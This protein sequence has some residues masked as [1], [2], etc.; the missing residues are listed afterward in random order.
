[1]ILNPLYYIKKYLEHKAIVLMYHR[2]A[3]ARA[4][5]WDIAV[6]PENLEEQLKFLKKT[7]SVIPLKE[8]VTEVQNKWI[9][10]N[11]IAITF[12]DGYAD[13]F[14]RAKPLLEKYQLPAT[15]FIPSIN[16]GKQKEF[17]WDELEHLILFTKHLPEHLSINI[18]GNKIE[19]DLVDEQQLND[20]II[21]K[22]IAW[23]AYKQ[24]PPTLRASLFYEIWEALKP[25]NNEQQQ[26]HL[27]ILRNWMGRNISIRTDYQC[28]SIEQIKELG[29]N[30]L[31]TIEAHS[32]THAALAFHDKIFQK[33]ELE[34]NKF[35][36]EKIMIKPIETVAYP[37]GSINKETVLAAMDVGFKA[38]FTTEEET[39][40]NKSQL[41]RLGRFQVKN[42]NAIVFS[43]NLEKWLI[44]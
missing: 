38:A 22:H 27:E 18:N 10:K 9:K 8:L 4:D 31:F 44:M 28:M 37:Y 3:D 19:F 17:W 16:I 39:I 11:S 32:E 23:K 24:E 29:A 20:E 35:F 34:L 33:K 5:V 41:Y 42:Q 25:L 21:S 13:N 7:H 43:N 15:F 12:D 30:E 36:L 1:M 6:S 40:S 2:I 14:Y 26:E